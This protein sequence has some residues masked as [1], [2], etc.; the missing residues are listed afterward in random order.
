MHAHSSKP[1]ALLTL[2]LL[3]GLSVVSLNM[4]L[5]SLANNAAEFNADYALVNLSITGYAAMA[6]ISGAL[7]TETN[8]AHAL[9]LMMLVPSVLSLLASLFVLRLETRQGRPGAL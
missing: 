8:V 4:F 6:A 1:P 2:I 5:P 9:L 7:L 3:C